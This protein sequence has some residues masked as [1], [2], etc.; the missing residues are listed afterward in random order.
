MNLSGFNRKCNQLKNK[1]TV[2]Q[3]DPSKKSD[4]KFSKYSYFT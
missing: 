1:Y 3:I 4:I 2:R